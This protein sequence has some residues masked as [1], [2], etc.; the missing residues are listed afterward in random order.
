M[1]YSFL[2][3]IGGGSGQN[4][5]H[6]LLGGLCHIFVIFFIVESFFG[7]LLRASRGFSVCN[8]FSCIK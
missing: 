8:H 6:F 3:S 2:A 7:L 4:N 1:Q 5:F